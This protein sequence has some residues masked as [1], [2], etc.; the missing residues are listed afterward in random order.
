MLGLYGKMTWGPLM[1]TA[2]LINAALLVGANL[3]VRHFDIAPVEWAWRSLVERR[4]LP[5]RKGA[6]VKPHAE[7]SPALA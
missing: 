1:V 5:W 2:F 6:R 3:W 4:V 7:G